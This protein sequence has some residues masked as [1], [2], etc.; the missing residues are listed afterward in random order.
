MRLAAASSSPVI[1]V[2]GG[3]FTERGEAALWDAYL[4][5]RTALF[6]GADLAVLLPYPWCASGAEDFARGG[7]F[8]AAALGSSSLTFGSESGDLGLLEKAAEIRGSADFA[9]RMKETA[10]A[11]RQSG[12][13]VQFDRV[14]RELGADVSLGPNDK[15]GLEYVRFGRAA[16]LDDFRPVRRLAPLPSA[17]EIRAVLRTDSP[18]L[19]RRIRVC[20]QPRDEEI[21]RRPD[22]PRTAPCHHRR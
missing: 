11:D 14:M 6:C 18:F 19:V 12:S 4:R 8:I 22:P 5:A 2:L 21:H 20:A 17:G 7:A 16:G 9:E 15:L 3:N 13:A 10:R 1:A